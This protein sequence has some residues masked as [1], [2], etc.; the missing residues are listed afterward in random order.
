MP[1]VSY[2]ICFFNAATRAF[3]AWL[4]RRCHEA[5]STE[6]HKAWRSAPPENRAEVARTQLAN[7]LSGALAGA[8]AAGDEV[9]AEIIED[10]VDFAAIADKWLRGV[11][12]DGR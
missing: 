4:S 1:P 8:Q 3:D 12:E 10:D 7:F 11:S 6:A 9:V 2:E 5:L